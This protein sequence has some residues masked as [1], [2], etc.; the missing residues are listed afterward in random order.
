MGGGSE[1][2]KSRGRLIEASCQ[3]SKCR[4]EAKRG[5]GGEGIN[6]RLTSRSITPLP[7][8]PMLKPQRPEKSTHVKFPFCSTAGQQSWAG[9]ALVEIQLMIR[10]GEA[11]VGAIEWMGKRVCGECKDDLREGIQPWEGV[12]KEEEGLQSHEHIP[13]L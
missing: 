13:W 7:P 11:R 8:L 2:I 1:G 5:V 3:L 4:A 12:W 6:P 9:P 10:K